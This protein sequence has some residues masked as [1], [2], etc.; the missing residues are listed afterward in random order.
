MKN[1]LKLNGKKIPLSEEQV[2]EIKKSFGITNISLSEV[3]EGDT[4]KIG[5]FEIIVLEQLGD[6]AA[7]I[8]K[9][10]IT[11][12]TKFGSNNNYENSYL[13]ELCNSF[14]DTIAGVIGADN[15]VE[16]TVDL[17]TNDGLKDYGKIKRK[18]HPLTADLYRKY[19]SILYKYKIDAWQWL[20]TADSTPTHSSD[21]FVLCV[22]PSGD[23][24]YNCYG[25]STSV[26]ARFVS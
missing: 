1:Y 16:H 22:S 6:T 20:A 18:M 4:A 15:L 26:F 23:I 13:D 24:Y 21:R 2:K 17:I 10:L 11:E 12:E 3:A 19:V 25:N 9:D 8:F 5:E 14:A 7:V